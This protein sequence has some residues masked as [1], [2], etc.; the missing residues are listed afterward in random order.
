[1]MLSLPHVSLFTT[2]VFQDDQFLEFVV[3]QVVDQ[4]PFSFCK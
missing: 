2:L 4:Q 3:P 1:M